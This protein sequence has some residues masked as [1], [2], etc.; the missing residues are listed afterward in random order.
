MDDGLLVPRIHMLKGDSEEEPI[1]TGKNHIKKMYRKAKELGVRFML[2][3]PA[4]A[5][6]EDAPRGVVGVQARGEKGKINGWRL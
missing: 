3:T 4:V 6:I 2:E 1:G 5:L